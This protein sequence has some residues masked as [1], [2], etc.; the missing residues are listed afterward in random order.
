MQLGDLVG[1][2]QDE[3]PSMM[4]LNMVSISLTYFTGYR[5]IQKSGRKPAG[6]KSKP[7]A[8]AAA[9]D[10][11]ESMGPPQSVPKKGKN[12]AV[13]VQMSDDDDDDEHNQ[14]QPAD[15]NMD[16]DAEMSDVENGEGVDVNESQEEEQ[17]EEDEEEEDE[18]LVD[19]TAEEDE[20]VRRDT[21]GLDLHNQPADGD[22]D[23]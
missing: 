13:A 4:N 15:S 2:L 7:P 12:A 11:S 8:S 17:G 10:P 18:E 6:A 14:D 23:I 3:L 21:E 1:P 16:V 9:T 19:Q 5:E 22:E 20:E